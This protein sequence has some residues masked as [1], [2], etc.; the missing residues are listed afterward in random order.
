MGDR[1]KTD[2]ER[3]RVLNELCRRVLRDFVGRKITPT[4]MLE[5]GATMR[6]AMDDAIRAGNY[7]VP[8]GLMLDR[9]EISHDMRLQVYFKKAELVST[10]LGYL[11]TMT[12]ESIEEAADRMQD[13]RRGPSG[14]EPSTAKLKN[15]YEAIAAEMNDE[16]SK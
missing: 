15:R 13:L 5:A 3:Q 12:L 6:A 4:L 16:D 14:S 7:V 1:T 2:A 10:T 9:V 8:D 11:P